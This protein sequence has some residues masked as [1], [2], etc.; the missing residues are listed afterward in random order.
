MNVGAQMK[1]FLEPK[2]VAII[3]V[4]RAPMTIQGTTLDVLTNLI[5][6]G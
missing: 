4:S 6:Q 3:G 5:K 1:K 2:S